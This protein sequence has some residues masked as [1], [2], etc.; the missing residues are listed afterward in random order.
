MSWSAVQIFARSRRGSLSRAR[1]S[2]RLCK[3]R[4]RTRKSMI[5][6]QIF[7]RI[8]SLHAV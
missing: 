1:T 2:R 5:T 3:N 7:A 4:S 8:Y 6:D